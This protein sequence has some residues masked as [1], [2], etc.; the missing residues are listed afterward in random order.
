MFGKRAGHVDV[1]ESGNVR[2]ADDYAGLVVQ[3]AGR[4][5]AHRLDIG[6]ADPSRPDGFLNAGA[7]AIHD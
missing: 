6:H 5:D 1:F 2:R 7:Y 3:R 4:G